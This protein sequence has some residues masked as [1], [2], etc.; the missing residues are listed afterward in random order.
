MVFQEFIRKSSGK[1]RSIADRDEY[2][3]FI[4]LVLRANT[5]YPTNLRNTNLVR[6]YALRAASWEF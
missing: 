2:H 5:I 4:A 6:T 1:I 3:R